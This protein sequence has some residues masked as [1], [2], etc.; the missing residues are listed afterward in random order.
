[1][2]NQTKIDFKTLQKHRYNT[3]PIFRI[4]FLLR[5]YAVVH[6]FLINNIDHPYGNTKIFAIFCGPCMVIDSR[7]KR[8]VMN[9]QLRKCFARAK[10]FRMKKARFSLAFFDFQKKPKVF[11]KARISKSGFKNAKLATLVVRRFCSFYCDDPSTMPKR[12]TYFRRPYLSKPPFKFQVQFVK[13]RNQGIQL[14]PCHCTTS[15]A[16]KIICE[17]CDVTAI[18]SSSSNWW[19]QDFP[20]HK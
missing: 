10:Q 19:L 13:G 3:I 5:N 11:K 1:M 12:I 8:L 17:H 2:H 15:P 20:C 14:L 18:F 7:K 16:K 4:I 9:M 6:L